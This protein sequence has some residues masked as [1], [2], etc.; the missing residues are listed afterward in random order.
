MTKKAWWVAA[1]LLV[2]PTM[3]QASPLSFRS[4][5]TFSL[6]EA[7]ERV[8]LMLQ[9]WKE[10]YG[11]SFYWAGERA[12]ISG[13]MFGV[14][15]DAELQIQGNEVSAE[16]TDPGPWLRKPAR[17]YLE[18]KLLKYLHPNFKDV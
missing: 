15:W 10:R 5:H 4:K 16:M 11:V 6:K 17:D 1:L 2:L 7:K 3:A 13:S 8:Q 12:Y 18:K 9:Y 14:H